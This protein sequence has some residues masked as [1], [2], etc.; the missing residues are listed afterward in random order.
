MVFTDMQTHRPSYTTWMKLLKWSSFIPLFVIVATLTTATIVEK[1]CGTDFANEHI[2]TSWWMMGLWSISALSGLAY[3]CLVRMWKSAATFTLHLS[4]I[5]ILAGA[6]TTHL[7]GTQGRMH[8]R[9]EALPTRSFYTSAHTERQLPF[10]LSLDTF[11]IEYYPN[12]TTAKDYVST[13]TIHDKQ[14][15]TMGATIAMNRIC[16]HQHY[17]LYQ[18]S[19]DDDL[20]GTILTISH[21]PYGITI[22]YAGYLMLLISAIGFFMQ[23]RSGLRNLLRS[24]TLAMRTIV[25]IGGICGALLAVVM[26]MSHTHGSEP[27]IPVLRSPLLSIHVSVIMMT[28]ALLACTFVCGIVAEWGHHKGDREKV[29]RLGVVSRIALYPAVILLAMGIFIGAV[30]ANVSWGRYWAWDPKE[31]WALITMLIYAAP[32]HKYSL[33]IFSNAKALHRYCIVAF[34][35]VLMTYFGVNFLLGGMHSYG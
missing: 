7:L 19:F 12:T 30:W 18:T 33:P 35:A 24:S 9:Q 29:E 16:T 1:Q 6:L 13:L 11:C 22:T 32:F 20:Q 34:L 5:L 28:Y 8:L 10:A 17:R 21:D 27:L 2:Y 15:G 23:K 31:V 4:F 3:L 25:I 14:K 26:V